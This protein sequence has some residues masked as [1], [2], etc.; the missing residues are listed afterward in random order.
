[1][2]NHHHSCKTGDGHK[3][4]RK[5]REQCQEEQNLNGN[6]QVLL[7]IG[8]FQVDINGSRYPCPR[9]GRTQGWGECEGNE[10]QCDCNFH[11]LQPNGLEDSVES[12]LVEKS[13]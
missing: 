7:S 9:L 5:K 11:D 12:P 13:P 6:T 3:D 1:M 4:R 2:E 8:S 10:Y